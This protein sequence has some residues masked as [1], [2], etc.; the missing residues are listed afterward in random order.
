MRRLWNNKKIG[1][2]ARQRARSAGL[3][4]SMLNHPGTIPESLLSNLISY[5]RYG[6]RSAEKSFLGRT[7][8]PNSEWLG[9]VKKKASRPPNMD[10]FSDTAKAY[11][12]EGYV[13]S[14]VWRIGERAMEALHNGDFVVFFTLTY[15]PHVIPFE[16]DIKQFVSS[17]PGKPDVIFVEEYHK[18]GRPHYHGLAFF[19]EI[20]DTWLNDPYPNRSILPAQALWPHGISMAMPF[21]IAENDAWSPYHKW[22]LHSSGKVP[23][24]ALHPLLAGQYL[25]KYMIKTPGVRVLLMTPGLGMKRLNAMLEPLGRRWKKDGSLAHLLRPS[26]V[27]TQWP[28]EL[29]QNLPLSLIQRKS[30]EERDNRILSSRWREAWI[31]MLT[32]TSIYSEI[33]GNLSND[34]VLPSLKEV[35]LAFSALAF[36]DVQFAR[37]LAAAEY[38][39]SLKHDIPP[40]QPTKVNFDAPI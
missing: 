32:K 25:C 14:L 34:Q 39:Q 9:V 40:Q 31:S 30:R 13:S 23:L 37:L 8:E 24:P 7:N 15:A 16:T 33:S 35:S 6:N 17:L 5:Q 2:L 4:Y 1:H 27:P 11:Q 21:R 26:T 10:W 29:R 22:P 12:A 36:P 38:W 3:T 18:T 20:P 19:S 28:Y